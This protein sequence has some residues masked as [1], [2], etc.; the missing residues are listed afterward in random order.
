MFLRRRPPVL[1]YR[2]VAVFPRRRQAA[3]SATVTGSNVTAP[4]T[5]PKP[6]GTVST[7]EVEPHCPL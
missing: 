1:R 4:A 5:A 6:S 7:A 3:G 2:P